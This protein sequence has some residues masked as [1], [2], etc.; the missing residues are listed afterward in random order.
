MLT[1]YKSKKLKPLDD[2]RK[3][4]S[5]DVNKQNAANNNTGVVAAKEQIVIMKERITALEKLLDIE[6]KLGNKNISKEEFENLKKEFKENKKSFIGKKFSVQKIEKLIKTREQQQAE[7]QKIN[8]QKVKISEIKEI[9]NNEW[10]SISMKFL[11]RGN[12]STILGTL[13]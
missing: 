6:T 3:N 5:K 2:Y 12:L 8:A 11:G 13:D 10:I 7:I 4:L 9:P 1:E